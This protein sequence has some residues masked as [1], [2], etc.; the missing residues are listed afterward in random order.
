MNKIIVSAMAVVATV[1][2][3][4]AGISLINDDFSGSPLTKD[5][6]LDR[7]STGWHAA[8]SG[9]WTHGSGNTW[10]FNTSNAG[11]FTSDGG[12]ATIVP[13]GGL[14]LSGENALDVN[15]TFNSWNGT[16]GD[17]I[18]VHLWGLVDATPTDGSIA[19]LGA[20]NGNMWVDAIASGFTVYNL[21]SGAQMTAGADGAAGAAAIQLLNQD[22]GTS[23]IGDAV[24]Y[25][26]TI[27]LS[28]YTVNTVGGYDYLVMGFGRNPGVG[29]GN[30]FAMH[31]VE[32]NAVPEPS[33]ALLIGLG[34]MA[35][36]LRRKK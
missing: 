36:T 30:S 2:T 16:T 23:L 11:G 25:N 26:T 7:N 21:G 31:D 13:L 14:G 8:S 27:D 12:I 20:Q 15:F 22:T 34:A 32:V 9:S 18:Y 24:D 33:S 4:M 10:I 5:G 35:F 3:S 6:A 28:S 19:N 17:N 1:S 29:T